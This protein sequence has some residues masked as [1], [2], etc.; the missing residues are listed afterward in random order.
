[1]ISIENYIHR[2]VLGGEKPTCEYIDG[3]LE[4]KPLPTKKHGIVQAN[5]AIWIGSNY[6]DLTPLTE[7]STRVTTTRFYVPDV[8]VQDDAHPIQGDYPGPNDPV[9][10]CIE[11]L[12]LDDRKAKIFAKCKEYHRWGVPYCWVID[13]EQKRAWV[14]HQ[15]LDEPQEVFEMISAGSIEIP[16][17]ALF[18]K[19]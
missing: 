14:F 8:S 3:V 9:P 18:N 15:G 1:M 2:F 5:I 13:P 16:F 4:Q 11:V 6:A 12:S 17:R 7:L 19:V 10:L